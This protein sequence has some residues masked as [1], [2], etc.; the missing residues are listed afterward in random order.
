MLAFTAN[1]NATQNRIKGMLHS[2]GYVLQLK[3]NDHARPMW[4]S[5]LGIPAQYSDVG[6]ET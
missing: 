5:V 1:I 4:G 2:E 3:I 6:W